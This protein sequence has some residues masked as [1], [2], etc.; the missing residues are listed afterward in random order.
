M[1]KINY[2]DLEDLYDNM[3]DLMADQ[4]E[5]N[6]LMQWDFGV[7]EFNEDDLMDELNELDEEL[8]ME[9]MNGSVPAGK[10]KVKEEGKNEED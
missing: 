9:E 8:A 1:K 7:G 2:N 3:A 5:I 4:E 6:E 10:A